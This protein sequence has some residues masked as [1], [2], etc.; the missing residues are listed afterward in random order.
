M[1]DLDLIK[2]QLYRTLNFISYKEKVQ[3]VDYSREKLTNDLAEWLEQYIFAVSS[4]ETTNVYNSD[5]TII[6]D[7]TILLDGFTFTIG[8]FSVN[9]T[10]GDVVVGGPFTA[11]SYF[12]NLTPTEDNALTDLFAYDSSDG[13]FKTIDLNT[14]QVNNTNIYNLDGTISEARTVTID[15]GASLN[16]TNYLNATSDLLSLYAVDTGFAGTNIVYSNSGDI[17]YNNTFGSSTDRT[18]ILI[19]D[20]SD[21]ILKTLDLSSINENNIYNADGAIEADRFISGDGLYS[22]NLGYVGGS[23]SGL[24]ATLD[25]GDT[26]AFTPEVFEINVES[27]VFH[28]ESDVAG[29]I[30]FYAGENISNNQTDVFLLGENIINQS[31]FVY[32]MTDGATI[33]VNSDGSAII[34]GDSNQID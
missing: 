25:N 31:Q 6:G 5:G 24:N 1:S 16:I 21:N 23:L 19:V 33:L 20:P 18:Q 10:S 22:L 29:D 3:L 26:L 13:S 11:D 2:S 28:F 14:I 4:G 8:D 27:G 30:I 15:S 9:G 17:T 32:T 34:G 7:R 12:V